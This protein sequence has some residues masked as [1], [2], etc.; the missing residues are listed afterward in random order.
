[1]NLLKFGFMGRYTMEAVNVET[2]VKRLL[3]EFDNLVTDIGLNQLGFGGVNPYCRVGS[4]ST[5]PANTDTTLVSQIGATGST[6]ANAAGYSSTA[7]WYSWNRDTYRFAAGVAAGNVSEVGIGWNTTG[8]TLFSRALV[9]DAEGNPTTIT[10]L[11]D[12]YLDVT[13]ECRLYSPT[14]D[15]SFPIV[16]SGVTY[17]V[18][19]R[20]AAANS[21]WSAQ[22][23]VRYGFVYPYAPSNLGLYTGSI[24]SITSGP[25]G[26]NTGSV[27][28]NYD[29]Y[30]A[31]SLKRTGKF[32]FDL[33][34]GNGSNKSMYLS[35]ING[36][37]QFEL[38]TPIVKTSDKILTLGFEYSWARH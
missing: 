28:G 8:P 17:N 19:G 31:N 9:K 38:D 30:S 15:T 13:Y 20:V 33:G 5:A 26:S 27:Q 35:N 34:V 1:M 2:G 25:G 10:V 4:G 6:T 7:P 11:S 21:G 36:Q 22:N 24:G 32:V 16:V 37:F 12:E 18:T 23:A 14:E 29:A 3:A